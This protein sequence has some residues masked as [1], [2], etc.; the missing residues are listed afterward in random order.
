MDVDNG[1]MRRLILATAACLTLTACGQKPATFQI[2]VTGPQ[3]ASATLSLCDKESP[4]KKKG[5]VFSVDRRITCSGE[6]DIRLKYPNGATYACHIQ[7]VTP[8]VPGHW[9]YYAQGP[10]CGLG[11]IELK[12]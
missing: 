9:K 7:Y 3:P 6:G 8:G 2:E 4:M 1:R 5:A 10:Q 12:K 11:E